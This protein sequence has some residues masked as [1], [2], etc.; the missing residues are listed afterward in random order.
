M[1]LTYQTS[2]KNIIMISCAILLT[3]C[4]VINKSEFNQLNDKALLAKYLYCPIDKVSIDTQSVK[5]YHT[6]LHS[7]EAKTIHVRCG[8]SLYTCVQLIQ[9]GRDD[10]P[11]NIQSSH[12]SNAPQQPGV[13]QG[14]G[15]QVLLLGGDI[16]KKSRFSCTLQ[17]G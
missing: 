16:I 8:K 10:D 3:S 17:N 6:P 4:A 9:W 7:A 15:N 1:F 11:L 13:R 12:P 14:T 5:I 2:Y